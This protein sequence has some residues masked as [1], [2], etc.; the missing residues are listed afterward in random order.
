[1]LHARTRNKD[2]KAG[3]IDTSSKARTGS[4][5]VQTWTT[6]K[7]GLLLSLAAP[8]LLLLLLP[9]LA[10]RLDSPEFQTS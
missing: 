8:D 9:G 2:A 6:V 4:D 3:R 1:M 5:R 10:P 7:A